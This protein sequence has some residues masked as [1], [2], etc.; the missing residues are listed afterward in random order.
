MA[1]G[2]PQGRSDRVVRPPPRRHRGNGFQQETVCKRLSQP[3]EQ[4][5]L[6]LRPR[7][8]PPSSGQTVTQMPL[9]GEFELLGRIAAAKLFLIIPHTSRYK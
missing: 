1:A 7:I 8:L 3:L 9:T 5:A 4:P 2:T 6:Q